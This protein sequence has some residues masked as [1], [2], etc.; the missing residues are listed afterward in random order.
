MQMF[1]VLKNLSKILLK[2]EEKP[3]SSLTVDSS[4]QEKLDKFINKY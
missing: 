3:L 4:I 1:V 2:I